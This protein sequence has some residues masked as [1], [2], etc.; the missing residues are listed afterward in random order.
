[1]ERTRSDTEHARSR[2]AR[3]VDSIA[4]GGLGIVSS[5]Q[6]QDTGLR[7]GEIRSLARQGV[8][9]RVHAGVYRTAGT[10]MST[11]R[12]LIAACLGVDGLVAASHRSALWLWGL[13][14][15]DPPIEISVR[16]ERHPEPRGV[17]IHRSRDLG[18]HH[19]TVLRGV[20]VTNAS[21]TLVDVGCVIHP[22]TF[23]NALET[24]LHRRLTTVPR[25]RAV[26]DEV[27]GRGRNGVGVLR[28]VLDERALGDA[29][30]ESVLEPLMARLC[31]HR[32]GIDVV[33]Q[34]ELV[35]GGRRIRPDFL[36]PDAKLVIEVDGLSVHG[37]REA[38]DGDLERQNLLIAHGYQ[39]LRYTI[40]HLRDPGRV[41]SQIHATA[42]RRRRELARTS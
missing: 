13:Y 26:I 35:I 37:T 1:M 19:L 29:R 17:V 22:T 24:A 34:H 18:P 12:H 30:P 11:R 14:H 5:R 27:A 3:A 9:E 7:P 33:Y 25:L 28:E 36:I 23:V 42:V 39:V 10:A 8:L 6:L 38:L 32:F 16:T 41:A 31:S 20:T 21:R 15:R 4:Q 2:K 40:T